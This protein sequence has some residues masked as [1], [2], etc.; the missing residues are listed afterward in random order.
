MHME[1][2]SCFYQTIAKNFGIKID[3]YCV[4]DFDTFEKVIN[5]VG[6]I[7][8]D[9]EEKEAQYLNTTNYISKKY[10][11][12]KA[13]KHT[14]NGNQALGYSRIRYVVSKKSGDGI[15]PYQQ[16]ESSYAGYL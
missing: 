12:V 8:I 13:G 6:G 14:L 16:P 5:E 3:K 1:E 9:L 15:R 7:E 2:W 11:N 4:V 10:R